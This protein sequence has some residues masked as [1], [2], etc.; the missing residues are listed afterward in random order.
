MPNISMN[1]IAV[2]GKKADVVNWLSIGLPK[3]KGEDDNKVEIYV[4]LARLQSIATRKRRRALC[5]RW[6]FF[7]RT[8]FYPIA[9]RTC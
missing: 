6:M 1:T 8:L 2:K 9:T 4:A 3:M 5:K 7:V